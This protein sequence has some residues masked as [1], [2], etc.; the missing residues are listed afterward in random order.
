MTG[1]RES[2]ENC[3]ERGGGGRGSHHSSWGLTTGVA[4]ASPTQPTKDAVACYIPPEPPL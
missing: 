1:D 3:W 4:R 2:G